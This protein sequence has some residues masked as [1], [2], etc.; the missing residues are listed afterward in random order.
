MYHP[1]SPK[2]FSIPIKRT[3]LPS[4]V[5]HHQYHILPSMHIILPS[6]KMTNVEKTKGKLKCVDLIKPN[7]IANLDKKNTLN[8]IEIKLL[9]YNNGGD[10]NDMD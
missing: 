6:E 3:L 10:S 9:E 8:S 4:D 1:N 2:N 5:M 7:N